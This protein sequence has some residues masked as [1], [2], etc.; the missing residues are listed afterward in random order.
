MVPVTVHPDNV[1]ERLK[2]VYKSYTENAKDAPVIDAESMH[3]FYREA[4]VDPKD[5]SAFVALSDNL[6]SFPPTYLTNCEFDPL[7]D[8]TTV[9]KTLLDEAGVPTKHDYYPSLPHYFW[10]FPSVP[11]SQQ[12]IGNLLAGIGWLQSQM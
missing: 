5:S 3:I 1:P 6:K 7:R 2:S 10:I 11:E 12:Y 4:A 9:I 8:D